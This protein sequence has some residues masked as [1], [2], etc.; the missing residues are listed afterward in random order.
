MFR[1]P[2]SF[3]IDDLISQREDSTSQAYQCKLLLTPEVYILERS[4]ENIA[5]CL[6]FLTILCETELSSRE[7]ME[8]FLDLYGNA[9]I[10]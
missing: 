9:L 2:S 8:L 6:L 7:R 3:E 1:Y 10:R 4:K 5:R